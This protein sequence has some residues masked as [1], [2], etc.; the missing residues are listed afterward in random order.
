L[1]ASLDS[2]GA[3][4]LDS[5][6]ALAISGTVGTNL[7]TDTPGGT[8]STP[9]FGATLIGNTLNLT[10]SGAVTTATTS[11]A[12]TAHGAGAHSQNAYVTVNGVGGAIINQ[13]VDGRRVRADQ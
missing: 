8:G 9:T 7:T 6:G 12:L 11:K 5:A 3:A 13:R 2:K 1:T 4:T 10:S